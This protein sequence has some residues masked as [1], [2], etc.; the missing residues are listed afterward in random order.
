MQVDTDKQGPK[1]L[2]KQTVGFVSMEHAL[3]H[4]WAGLNLRKTAKLFFVM[5]GDSHIRLA[6]C[7]SAVTSILFGHKP[8]P[9]ALPMLYWRCYLLQS[10]T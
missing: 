8:V 5:Q 4:S 1:V 3:F 7:V 9:L 10:G 6:S 2:E